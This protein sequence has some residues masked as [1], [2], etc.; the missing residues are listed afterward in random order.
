MVLIK[1][2]L[3]VSGSSSAYS[4]SI[5]VLFFTYLHLVVV[6]MQAESGSIHNAKMRGH[7]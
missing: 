4:E 1:G 2:C 6:L 7:P 5:K 3:R